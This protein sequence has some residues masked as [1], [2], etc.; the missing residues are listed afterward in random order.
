MVTSTML[1]RSA[2][3]AGDGSGDWGDG[4]QGIARDAQTAGTSARHML[5]SY[6]HGG[7][8]SPEEAVTRADAWS[9][10]LRRRDPSGGDHFAVARVG[11]ASSGLPGTSHG[12]PA[13]VEDREGASGAR[14]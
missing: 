8:E 10:R 12:S 9:S 11:E 13:S 1:G 4:A 14:G 7:R 3:P 5:R 6:R 2:P